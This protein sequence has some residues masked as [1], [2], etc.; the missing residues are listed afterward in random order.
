MP[1]VIR[2]RGLVVNISH[3]YWYLGGSLG[4]PGELP[5]EPHSLAG[6][7]FQ[8]FVVGAFVLGFLVCLAIARGWATGA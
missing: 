3:V 5:G 1:S 6:W 7:I 4:S 8:V 2:R